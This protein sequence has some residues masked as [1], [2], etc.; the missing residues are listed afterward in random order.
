MQLF[1]II[2]YNAKQLFYVK[3]GMNH[4]A[5]LNHLLCTHFNNFIICL[6]PKQSAYNIY[7]STT[8]I[9]TLKLKCWWAHGHNFHIAF[10]R[11][12]YDKMISCSQA[13][14]LYSFKC[15]QNLDRYIDRLLVFEFLCLLGLIYFISV[16]ICIGMK[17]VEKT[18]VS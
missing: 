18:W 6:A 11:N 8:L 15:L 12:Q 14:I 3:Y 13:W 4:P 16:Y 9:G 2:M 7:N 10:P 1:Y 17:V 5:I